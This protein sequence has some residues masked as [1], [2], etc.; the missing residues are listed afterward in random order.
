MSYNI[1]QG[2]MGQ[3]LCGFLSAE[4]IAIDP[5]SSHALALLGENKSPSQERGRRLWRRASAPDSRHAGPVFLGV[6]RLKQC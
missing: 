5:S 4:S 1:T 3:R 2:E 6:R